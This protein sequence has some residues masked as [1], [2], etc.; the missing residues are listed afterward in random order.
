MKMVLFLFQNLAAHLQRGLGLAALAV[1]Q[2]DALAIAQAQHAHGVVGERV[3]QFSS[4][5]AGRRP[6]K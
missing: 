3:E 2:H 4:P 6:G 1:E 5:A